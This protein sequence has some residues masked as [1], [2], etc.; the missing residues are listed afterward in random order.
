MVVEDSQSGIL[1][2]VGYLEILTSALEDLG[3]PESSSISPSSGVTSGT[4][5]S[6]PKAPLRSHHSP[7]TD[8]IHSSSRWELIVHFRS[9][10]FAPG[11]SVRLPL[12]CAGPV[13]AGHPT[14]DNIR[15]VA[16]TP[17]AAS[18]GPGSDAEHAHLKWEQEHRTRHL[19]WRD[20][21]GHDEGRY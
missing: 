6:W 2:V 7:G 14:R 17:P 19:G 5:S 15:A 3:C 16:R 4:S 10:R 11:S 8:S 1:S 9:T 12:V 20:H 18:R 21:C 13:R